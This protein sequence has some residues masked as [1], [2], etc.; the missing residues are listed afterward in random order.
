MR[1]VS[2]SNNYKN[3]TPIE[4]LDL[5]RKSKCFT[6]FYAKQITYYNIKINIIGLI[7]SWTFN[8]K[9]FP[10]SADNRI[11]LAI[12]SQNMKPTHNI[13]HILAQA[14]TN[15]VMFSRV[16]EKRL[17]YYDDCREYNKSHNDFQS[18]IDCLEDCKFKLNNRSCH[19][20]IIRNSLYILF[21]HQLS[22]LTRKED[23]KCLME[24]TYIELVNYCNDKCEEDCYQVYYLT[25][26]IKLKEYKSIRTLNRGGQIGIQPNSNPNILIE[27]F[28]EITFI[29]LICYFGGLI[30]MYLGI[31]ITIDIL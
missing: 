9:W 16:E 22:N 6:Y 1:Q 30:G 21:R 20:E 27:H 5:K 17:I 4:S 28:P 29:S 15:M 10:F 23:L 2:E 18:R 11:S 31:F 7:I 24:K 12:H 3:H 13:F 19:N 25:T 26:N 14:S 8:F